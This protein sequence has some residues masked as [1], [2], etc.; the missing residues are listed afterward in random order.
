MNAV[1]GGLAAFLLGGALAPGGGVVW[2]A[3]AWQPALGAVVAAV[4]WGMAALGRR[5]GRAGLARAGELALWGV[6]LAA[7]VVALAR[8]VWVA[9]SGREEPGLL[10]GLVDA[11]ASLS[12]LA[13]G[14]P[15]SDEASARVVE[16]AGEGASLFHFADKLASGPPLAFS[17]AGTDV[18]AAL[19]ALDD[20]VAGQ[21]L[22]GIVLVSDGLDRGPLRRRF[23]EEG[24]SA[25][26]PPLAGPL[27]VVQ[28]GRPE[29]LSDLS[30]RDVD[31]GGF[32]YVRTPFSV[33]AALK[34]V[35]YAG[36]TVPVQLLRDGALV[37]TQEVTLDEDGLAD[38][39]FEVRPDRAGRFAYA[40]SVPAFEGDAV[41]SNNL[42]PVVVRVVRDRLRV[43]QVA[44][45]PSWDVKFLR[46]FLKGD[47]SVDLV[48]FFILRTIDDIRRREWSEDEL[49]LIQFPYEQ[50][51]DEDLSTFDL[52]I[53]QNFDHRP[54][55]AGSADALLANLARFVKDDG[56]A[57]VMVGGDLSF[58][59]GQYGGTPLEAVLPVRISR[60]PVQPD[61]TPFR[62]TLTAAGAR[63]PVTRLVRDPVENAAW[64][65]RLHTLDGTNQLLG[66]QPGASVLLAHPSLRAGS[67]PLPVLAVRE[68]GK[69]RTMALSVDTSWR[70]S[71]SEA[72]E[73]R[74]N[75]AYLRF[76]KNAM[77]WLVS[78]ET[79]KRV[80]VE[81]SRENWR[82]GEDVRLLV[83][84]RDADFAPAADA[85]VTATLT[86][87]GA[88]T[89]LEGVTGPDGE[90]ALRVPA[91]ARGTW[92]VRVSVQGVEGP[93]G[94]AETV[95]AVTSRDP[96]LD[97]VVPDEAFLRWLAERSGGR[98]IGPGEALEPLRDASATRTRLDRVEVAVWRS[99]GLLGLAALCAGLAWL[100]RRRS[101]LR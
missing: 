80:V 72:A 53:F 97:E 11:S 56:H 33:S 71:L 38:V 100:V 28:V 59:L 91:T 6:A 39:R 43:L 95:F 82:V 87:D 34:G 90:L 49:S 67:G 78:D 86:V 18:D 14:A 44:G 75:Q 98:F 36:R 23:Q 16:L 52:V 13:Q 41:P 96:E 10:V 7:L 35:G 22:A 45:A 99:P 21:E 54:Y 81:P 51:F 58:S 8:P 57:F 94:T 69:G 48:S 30:V 62:A 79:T 63:H 42:A 19:R 32:A 66:A 3:P 50:L 88:P 76:W 15:R 9:E 5:Q 93:L 17:G 40:V 31:A 85:A 73:G 46:R 84:A 77:R 60:A 37:A 24:P 47:P 12:V 83:T 27:T 55:F 26:L 89:T 4:L 29:G 68:V 92:R 1:W 74:G 70:W 20:R 65:E 61:L 64:W 2:T 25:P 101:G